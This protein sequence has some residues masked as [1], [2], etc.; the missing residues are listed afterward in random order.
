MFKKIL[1]VGLLSTILASSLFA[2]TCNY[3]FGINSYPGFS[4]ASIPISLESGTPILL[5]SLRNKF[6][7]PINGGAYYMNGNI[8]L[9]PSPD[10]TLIVY[11]KKSGGQ[12]LNAV[13]GSTGHYYNV[14]YDTNYGDDS[15]SIDSLQVINLN[16][17]TESNTYDD[18]ALKSENAILKAKVQAL[19]TKVYQCVQ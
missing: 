10:C 13:P 7:Y 19:E 1:L 18:T 6:S 17:F 5:S 8:T 16:T 4:D 2:K 15:A 12:S 11:D 3:K 14:G 9:Y